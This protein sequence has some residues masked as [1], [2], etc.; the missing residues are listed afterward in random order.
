M[1]TPDY[2]E[3]GIST[4]KYQKCRLGVLV[5]AFKHGLVRYTIHMYWTS[6]QIV[7]ACAL[8]AAFKYGL[9]PA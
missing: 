8:C 9:T 4:I 7:R 2:E 5:S 3:H 1:T 6:V